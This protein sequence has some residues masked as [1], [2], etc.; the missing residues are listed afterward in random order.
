MANT[1]P[2]RRQVALVRHAEL[3]QRRRL[4]SGPCPVDVRSNYN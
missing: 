4:R 2:G 3:E 1:D